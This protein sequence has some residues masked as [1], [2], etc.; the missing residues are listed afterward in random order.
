[1]K[2]SRA[3]VLRPLSA[4]RGLG[5]DPGGFSTEACELTIKPDPEPG[6]RGTGAP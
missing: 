1:M 6:T 3:F 2:Q 5:P 4:V